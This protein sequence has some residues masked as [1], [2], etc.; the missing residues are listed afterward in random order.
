M[1]TIRWPSK[2]MNTHC[3]R[4]LPLLTKLIEVSSDAKL[5]DSF[6][7]AAPGDFEIEGHFV[8]ENNLY[9]GFK[10]PLSSA[11]ES[12][13]LVIQ[14]VER[15]FKQKAID[16]SQLIS[17]KFV[18]FGGG[19]GSPQRL[20]DMIRVQGRLYVTTVCQNEDCGGIWRLQ[21][22]DG[23]INPEEIKKFEA[24]KPEG[25]AFDPEDSSFFVTFDM[26]QATSKFLRIP[27]VDSG[28]KPNVQK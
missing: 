19:T 21:E 13:I 20:S 14:D 16:P 11:K 6:K 23:R 25:I 5:K 18:N 27:L 8:D 12:I 24:L 10:N 3:T 9:V 17:V 28:V 26:K 2:S 4:W 22:A 1:S 15:I 7:K